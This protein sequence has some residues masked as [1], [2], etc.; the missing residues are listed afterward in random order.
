MTFSSGI[1]SVRS[2]G[3]VAT[4]ASRS[5]ITARC[6]ARV[7]TAATDGGA[8]TTLTRRRTLGGLLFAALSLPSVASPLAAVADPTESSA[9]TTT[10]TYT[11]AIDGWQIDV[12][13]SWT[14]G[15]GTLGDKPANRFS[16]AAGLQRVVGWVA[17]TSPTTSLAVT[18]KT[19]GADY[20]GLGSFGKVDD[21]AENL[22]ASIDRSFMARARFGAGKN[23]D[24]VVTASLVSS[25]EV[26][27]GDNKK[28]LV[29]YVTGKTGEPTRRVFT[30]VSFGESGVLRRFYTV[31]ASCLE[32][33]VGA[34][35]EIL[36]EAVSS[37]QP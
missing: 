18:V 36:R 26:G 20:T 3:R 28:Y 9:A 37:F 31:T 12:P 10:K 32:D 35:A 5:H 27:S 21:W 16:N 8:T 34:D 24:P 22:I 11:D 29:E 33:D 17:P 23:A 25:K 1:R 13:M 2:T 7:D 30:A 6:N 4:I 19:P 15:E 14:Q